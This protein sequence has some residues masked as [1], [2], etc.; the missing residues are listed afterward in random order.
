[1]SLTSFPFLSLANAQF[2]VVTTDTLQGTVTNNVTNSITNTSILLSQSVFSNNLSFGIN[3]QSVYQNFVTQGPANTTASVIFSTISGLSNNVGSIWSA[4]ID[5]IGMTTNSG[6]MSKSSYLVGKTFPSSSIYVTNNGNSFSSNNDVFGLPIVSYDNTNNNIIICQ[7]GTGITSDDGQSYYTIQSIWTPIYG[8]MTTPSFSSSNSI[9]TG[10][11]ISSLSITNTSSIQTS[12]TPANVSITVNGSNV[13]PTG[14]LS[15][16]YTA[17]GT[18]V[19]SYGPLSLTGGEWIG[20][21]PN[22]TYFANSTNQVSSVTGSYQFTVNYSGDSNYEPSTNYFNIFVTGNNS[23]SLSVMIPAYDQ[24]PS[25][26]SQSSDGDDVEALISVIGS[27]PAT[28]GTISGT[29][30]LPGIYS[31]NFGPITLSIYSGQGS[32]TLYFPSGAISGSIIASEH[33][34][35]TYNF[36]VNYSGNSYYAPSSTTFSIVET[37]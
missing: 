11:L 15:I 23:S 34:T 8:T 16:S 12:G 2:N 19:G 25:S 24:G 35:G 22:N 27:G 18:Y 7:I 20:S 28:T 13:T 37:S 31:G 21:F 33:Y 32:H 26:Y 29:C 30:T 10:N 9:I 14:L 1:M 4:S 36:V 17:A 3:S 6:N 5:M